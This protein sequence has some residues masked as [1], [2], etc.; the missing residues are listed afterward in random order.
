MLNAFVFCIHL[1]DYPFDEKERHGIDTTATIAKLKID[2]HGNIDK[3][4]TEINK[5]VE[6]VL[7]DGVA[8]SGGWDNGGFCGLPKSQ[9]RRK[10]N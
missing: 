4:G 1:A 3:Y 8:F 7:Y 9:V 6:L 2:K 5:T 10:K